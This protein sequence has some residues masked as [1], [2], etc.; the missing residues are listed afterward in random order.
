MYDLNKVQINLNRLIQ[1]A[2]KE[3]PDAVGFTTIITYWEDDTYQI[4]YRHDNEFAYRF[5]FESQEPDHISYFEDVV[6]T[7]V[8]IEPVPSYNLVKRIPL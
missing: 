3:M 2:K 1:V 4:D 8:A 7:L 5:V 6:E